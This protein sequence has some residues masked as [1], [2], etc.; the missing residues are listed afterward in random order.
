VPLE[1]WHQIDRKPG[2]DVRVVTS[3]RSKDAEDPNWHHFRGRRVESRPSRTG[4]ASYPFVRLRLRQDGRMGYPT[5]V[6][7]NVALARELER[8]PLLVSAI[9]KLPV[10]GPATVGDLSLEG[11]EVGDRKRHG[12]TY[13]AIYAYAHED[14]DWWSEQLGKGIRP[15]LFGENLTTR[16]LDLNTCVI[17]EQWLVGTARLQVSS[18]RVGCGT[19]ARWL[20]LQGFEV[21]D[22]WEKRFTERGRP[23]VYLSIL[24][25]GWIQAGDPIDVIDRPDHGLTAAAMFRAMTTEP[26]LLPLLL[27]VEGLPAHAYERAQRYV[28][29]L[30]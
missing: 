25:R 29:T 19:F 5:V 30:A 7:V 21:G 23:G 15:G 6:S 13:Q 24:G 4:H 28:D 22:G 1:N 8:K 2:S 16:G 11:D 27:E 17:G 20:D 3:Y 10:H 9:D 12:G 26:S 14:L 18:V